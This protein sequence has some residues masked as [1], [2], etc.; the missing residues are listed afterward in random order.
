MAADPTSLQLGCQ[1]R[2]VR[3]HFPEAPRPREHA[4]A[5]C[6]VI[7]QAPGWPARHSGLRST[8]SGLCPSLRMGNSPSP[9]TM[10]TNT[11]SEGHLGSSFHLHSPLYSLGTI[12]LHINL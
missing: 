6:S 8:S 5:P 7:G 1:P 12:F 2:T 4:R 3:A 9:C 11:L 10:P